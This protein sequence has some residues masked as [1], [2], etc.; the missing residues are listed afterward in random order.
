MED[1][2][3]EQVLS[4]PP[5]P[6][7]NQTRTARVCE[8]DPATVE[9]KNVRDVWM[10]NVKHAVQKRGETGMR[11]NGHVADRYGV[12]GA[13][14]RGAKRGYK[15]H[16]MECCEREAACKQIQH[17]THGTC[18]SEGTETDGTRGWR[19]DVPIALR[20]VAGWGARWWEKAVKGMA[21]WARV[22][23]TAHL[24]PAGGRSG[25]ERGSG[26]RKGV[27]GQ[28]EARDRATEGRHSVRGGDRS[29]ENG[30]S[31]E[32]H[33]LS[34]GGSMQT[35]L[36]DR[37]SGIWDGDVPPGRGKE[38]WDSVVSGSDG[39]GECIRENH[40][41]EQANTGGI[42]GLDERGARYHTRLRGEVDSN[43]GHGE[44]QQ[45]RERGSEGGGQGV[46]GSC[47]PSGGMEGAPEVQRIH[48]GGG[49]CSTCGGH[50]TCAQHRLRGADAYEATQAC[51]EECI[52]EG[53]NAASGPATVTGHVDPADGCDAADGEADQIA[54]SGHH[55]DCAHRGACALQVRVERGPGKDRGGEE[56][57]LPSLYGGD[58][59]GGDDR[60]ERES[61]RDA[62]GGRDQDSTHPSVLEH[63]GWVSGGSACDGREEAGRIGDEGKVGRTGKE[64]A[65]DRR[66]G[67]GEG[68]RNGSEVSERG[69]GSRER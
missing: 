46:S 9:R 22:A 61:A 28:G 13:R 29:G 59:T 36:S 15:T 7:Q 45:V 8:T 69:Q 20:S 33:G 30:K 10:R 24:P 19:T 40:R 25:R 16:T 1:F 31:G 48:M 52:P 50:S 35:A 6:S 37:S 54:G 12:N 47:M 17:S 56:T 41:R 67:S 4:A 23:L 34:G 63:P 38:T 42:T 32:E 44:I 5:P 39:G 64:D 11:E 27:D 66:V 57:T 18:A 21:K 65:G 43:Y 55:A 14:G 49:E 3:F 58:S 2:E 53:C 60:G 51:G 68:V 62:R 26:M